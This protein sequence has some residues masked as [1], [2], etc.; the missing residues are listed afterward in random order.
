MTMTTS[1]IFSRG[2]E[3]PQMPLRKVVFG[4]KWGKEGKLDNW[5]SDH[6]GDD[7]FRCWTGFDAL[8]A[9]W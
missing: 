4:G 6:S 3:L 1:S 5:G 8:A 9:G 7:C 2:S